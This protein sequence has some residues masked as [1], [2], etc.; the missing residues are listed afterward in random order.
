[1]DSDRG[2]V[3]TRPKSILVIDD[4]DSILRL[5]AL[6]FAPRYRC[7]TAPS[8]EAA[9]EIMEHETFDV[10]LTDLRLTGADGFAVCEFVRAHHP[11][12]VLMMMTGMEGAV[13]ARRALEAGVMSFVTKPIE[14][15]LLERL[16]ENAF[17]HQA[18]LASRQTGHR[19]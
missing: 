6:H 7:V 10:V 18:K 2:T 4:E 3:A 16:I 8:A 13:Q 11:Q 1:M 14:F 5:M 15:P 9:F 19:R 17:R 12:A